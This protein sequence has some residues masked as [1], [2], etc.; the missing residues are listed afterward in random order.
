LTSTILDRAYGI[1]HHV[2]VRLEA[3]GESRLVACSGYSDA[4]ARHME[5]A[6]AKAP[7]LVGGGSHVRAP[8]DLFAAAELG[9]PLRVA[10][11]EPDP[12][13]V[14]TVDHEG[15]L[16][17]LVGGSPM[18]SPALVSQLADVLPVVLSFERKLHETVRGYEFARSTL[19]EVPIGL[20][21]VDPGGRVLFLN[22]AAEQILGT[23]VGGSVGE[24]SL[25]IFRTLVDGENVLLQ[26]LEGTSTPIE[27]WLR[28]VDERE[29]PVEL[30]LFH[31]RASDGTLLGVVSA[32]QDLSNLRTMQEQLRH[33]ERLATIGEL[34][35]GIAHEIGNPLTGIRG[36]AQILRDRYAADP[37]ATKL[38]S[39]ILEEVDRLSRLSHHVR[40][41]VR[42][43]LPRMRKYNVAEIIDRVVELWEPKARE[44]GVD[45]RC[46]AAGEVPEVYLDADQIHQVLHNLVGNAIDA[47]SSSGG[48]VE[49]QTRR[50]RL[51]VSNPPRRRRSGDRGERTTRER[52]FVRI[53]VT[54]TGVG[55]AETE[56]V[57]VFQPFFTTKPDG[58]G[59]GLSISQTIVGEHAGFLTVVSQLGKGSTFSVDLPVDRRAD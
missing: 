37:S 31:V 4:T 12:E 45:I 7:R 51:P 56:L 9:D 38:V 25:R 20:I 50:M 42:P 48:V 57:R 34:A 14:A 16:G 22:A 29:I 55:M 54:D 36:C 2:L 43:S 21:A 27:I 1:A 41:F 23:S 18:P 15:E 3:R 6:L 58:L 44:L 59:L 39:V 33:R 49:I 46:H 24:D 17:V 40:Q 13:W 52:E 26:G 35:A 8:V 32:F 19:R 10:P 47:M 11:G 53:S 28:R 30:R 5:T